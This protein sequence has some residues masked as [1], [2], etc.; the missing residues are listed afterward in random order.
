MICEAWLSYNNGLLSFDNFN[1]IITIID[2][3]FK[4]IGLSDAVC[5][6][7]IS[8]CMRDK[9]NHSDKILCVQ[10]E[11]IGKAVYDIEVSQSQIEQS[12][13]FYRGI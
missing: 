12:L 7:I 11:A 4:R 2:S 10:L 8:N 13:A 3:S 5:K 9:K 1:T 6:A